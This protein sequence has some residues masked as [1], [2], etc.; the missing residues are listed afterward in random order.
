MQGKTQRVSIVPIW[1]DPFIVSPFKSQY[2][3]EKGH[4]FKQH[5]AITSNSSGPSQRAEI[6]QEKVPVVQ[7]SS[8]QLS[9][10]SSTK[11]DFKRIATLPK[12][13]EILQQERQGLPGLPQQPSDQQKVPVIQQASPQLSI[14]PLAKEDLEST[15]MSIADGYSQRDGERPPRLPQL[16][17]P[18]GAPTKL[19]LTPLRDAAPSLMQSSG[20]RNKVIS[21]GNTR[22]PDFV[23]TKPLLAWERDIKEF[24]FLNS[25]SV[26]T[27]SLFGVYDDWVVSASSGVLIFTLSSRAVLYSTVRK[28][29]R[30]I[31]YGLHAKS[32]SSV[33]H[34]LSPDEKT[35]VRWISREVKQG[36]SL[37]AID[38]RSEQQMAEIQ[39]DSKCQQ[40]DILNARWVDN[41]TIYIPVSN[42]GIIIL[43]II[44][45]AR[46]NLLE[47]DRTIQPSFDPL[48]A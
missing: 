17:E 14:L 16:Q 7:Q 43:W 38:V 34:N 46:Y 25:Q 10:L 21:R 11:E 27:P 4:I 8:P 42:E 6:N 18:S 47:A 31:D 32:P 40:Y 20:S 39:R 22:R 24:Q 13:D 2:F 36:S 23:S 5:S 19:T 9:T 3:P 15:S 26:C 44:R 35:L 30:K 41:S 37:L 48:L 33:A 28:T 1:G 29:A 45:D 12:A